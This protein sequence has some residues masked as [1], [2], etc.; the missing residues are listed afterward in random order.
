MPDGA[1]GFD[2]SLR[3][4]PGDRIA[5]EFG[6]GRHYA[7]LLPKLTVSFGYDSDD[8]H[9]V[10]SHSEA[11]ALIK[12]RYPDAH[13]RPYAIDEQ[14]GAFVPTPSSEGMVIIAGFYPSE[15][16]F[17]RQDFTLAGHTLARRLTGAGTIRW[18]C[19]PD[20]DAGV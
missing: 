9:E 6:D 20:R 15:A 11:I 7:V 19:R 1:R 17:L 18:E 5:L 10:A 16:E 13:I 8:R 3:M 14:T 12:S 4:N 2:T